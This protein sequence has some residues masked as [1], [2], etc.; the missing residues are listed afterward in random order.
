M[1]NHCT[2]WTP[3]VKRLQSPLSNVCGHYCVAYLLLRCIAVP[4]RTFVNIF[5]T[6]LVA[7]DCRVLDWVKHPHVTSSSSYHIV[8]TLY[9]PLASCLMFLLLNKTR[10]HTNYCVCS[11]SLV[12][13]TPYTREL[14][15]NNPLIRSLTFF[16]RDDPLHS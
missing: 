15:F 7:N 1:N 14:L 3:N 12:E 13:T 11:F 6:D 5:G 2:D 16:S 8:I 10:L 4:M 9:F